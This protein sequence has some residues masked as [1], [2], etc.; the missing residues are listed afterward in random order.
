MKE[1]YHYSYSNSYEFTI[2]SH[3]GLFFLKRGNDPKNNTIAKSDIKF[4]L[5]AWIDG[6][7]KGLNDGSNKYF[8]KYLELKMKLKKLEIKN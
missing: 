3:A 8:K 1:V 6:W 5:M 2:Y 7:D 4:T